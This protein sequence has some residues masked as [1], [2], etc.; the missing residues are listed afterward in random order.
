MNKLYGLL[1]D[2]AFI[3]AA[4]S[5]TAATLAY[6]NLDLPDYASSA[7]EWT[8]LVGLPLLGGYLLPNQKQRDLQKELESK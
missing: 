5:L 3:T 6:F 1:K 4:L 7:L 2:K 8:F